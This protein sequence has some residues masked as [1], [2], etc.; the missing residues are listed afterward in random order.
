MK[1]RIII[2]GGMGPQASLEL[3]RRI[4]TRAAD[5]GARENE[6]YP[7]IVHV[8]IPVPDFISSGNSK[9]GLLRLKQS[10]RT[11]GFHDTDKVILACNTAHLLLPEIEA[12]FGVRFIS[13]I[14][15]VS[16]VIKHN[17]FKTIGLLASPTTIK[18]QLYSKPIQV[19]GGVVILPTSQEIGTLENAIRHI[20]ANGSADD[21]RGLIEPIVQRM[22]QDGAEQVILGCTE[23]SVI[24]KDSKKGYL[25]D[26]LNAV[27]LKLN[28]ISTDSIKNQK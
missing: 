24:F 2:I 22:V 28:N 1:Q 17:N 26:P 19:N 5:A 6:D 4:I 14:D 7:E 23:L 16:D 3:H 27:C 20:I 12:Q 10:L 18:K 13:L 9:K 11:I 8:S 15:A 21:V 25:L